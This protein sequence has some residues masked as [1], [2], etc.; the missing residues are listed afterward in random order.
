[1]TSGPTSAIRALVLSEPSTITAPSSSPSSC[2]PQ[3]PMKIEAGGKLNSRNPSAEPQ[4]IA[5]SGEVHDVHQRDEPEH[6]QRPAGVAEADV[7]HERQREVVDADA[8]DD[9]H[10]G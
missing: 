2:E 5:A 10:D 4:T 3:S 6:G 8:A 1:M 9:Q 7:V